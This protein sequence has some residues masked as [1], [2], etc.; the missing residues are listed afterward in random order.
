MLLEGKVCV[1]TG[2]SGSIGLATARAFLREGAKVMLVDR[3][4][5][6]LARAATELASPNVATIAADV[7]QEE[8]TR[9][10][11][12]AAS[13]KWGPIDVLFSN[14]GIGGPVAPLPDYPTDAF[15]QVIA[16]HVRGAFLAC[17]YG[18]PKMRDG[19]SV[20]ITAS[21]ASF[22]AL[23]GGVIGY[24]AAK[25]AQLG[26]MR[27]VAREAAPRRIRVNT[28]H[29]GG[30]D[31][32]FMATMVGDVMRM[33]GLDPRDFRPTNALARRGA[34]EEIASAVLFLASDMSSFMT[35]TPLCVDGGS[36]L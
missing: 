14:A 32:Q 23:G 18:I 24:I 5:E 10:Y 21:N 34:P 8:S 35:G 28:I 9:A 25:H 7:S 16:V 13:D 17:R 31:N 12:E 2:G 3:R 29:P 11:I 22:S 1:V 4:E 20:I 30:V 27:T 6:D 19:G 15:D 33:R 26:I 36:F